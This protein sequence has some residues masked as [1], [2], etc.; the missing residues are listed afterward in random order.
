[1]TV[2]LKLVQTHNVIFHYLDFFILSFDKKGKLHVFFYGAISLLTYIEWIAS[3]GQNNYY[4]N[5][6][7]DLP[8]VAD[9]DRCHVGVIIP[10]QTL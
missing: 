5:V 10:K 4:I 9:D 8:R 7:V 3:A 2:F 1:M 6:G